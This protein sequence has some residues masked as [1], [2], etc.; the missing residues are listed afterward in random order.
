[1]AVTAMA[2]R[3]TRTGYPDAMPPLAPVLRT[4]RM[5]IQLV[6]VPNAGWAA[7]TRDLLT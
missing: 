4:R 7:S 2:A 5:D 1:M 3:V 6:P